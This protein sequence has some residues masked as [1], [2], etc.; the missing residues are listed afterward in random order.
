[1]RFFSRAICWIARPEE[2]PRRP[3]AHRRPGCRSTRAPAPPRHPACSGRRPAP[4]RSAGP[5]PTRRN[6]ATANSTATLLPGPPTSRYG[7]PMSDSRP[8][9]TGFEV[10]C[11]RM[12]P[13][14]RQRRRRDAAQQQAAR[15]IR[16][17]V[18]LP[19]DR[20]DCCGLAPRQSAGFGR[21]REALRAL[22]LGG[23]Y[24]RRRLGPRSAAR[25]PVTPG[26][27]PSSKKSH[28]RKWNTPVS[29]PPS[30]R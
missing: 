26:C 25:T 3:S 2:L 19:L 4:P 15:E 21:R 9:F 8:S 29:V 6:P 1:M 14:H 12:M 20:A 7:P 18:R 17:R 11:A 10:L 27:V 24:G 30:I 28:A 16:H 22:A 13:G 23:R 5:A